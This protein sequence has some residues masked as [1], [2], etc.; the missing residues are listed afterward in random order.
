[1]MPV[2]DSYKIQMRLC[3]EAIFDSGER[4]RNTVQSKV[5]SDSYGFVYFHAKTLKG[6]LKKQA[7]W[8]LK[9]YKTIDEIQKTN[10]G[11]SF[12][13]SIVRLF[14]FNSQET[15]KLPEGNKYNSNRGSVPGVMRLSNLELDETIRRYFIQLHQEDLEQDYFRLS[16]YELINAQTNVRIGIQMEDGVI[17]NNMFNSYHTVKEGMYFY[18]NVTFEDVSEVKQPVIDDLARIIYSFKRIGAG[19]HRGRGE[20]SAQLLVGKDNKPYH[21][22]IAS[23]DGGARNV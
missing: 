12:Y 13:E 17:K 18:S 2:C 3:S 21:T 5:L 23:G 7:Y 15:S 14:G 16:P 10:Y 11:E 19:I 20:I 22:L 1:M 9:Q 6:Q 8:L 4:E